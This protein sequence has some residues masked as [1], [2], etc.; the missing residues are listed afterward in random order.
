MYLEILA[1]IILAIRNIVLKQVPG[2][3]D[4]IT[5]FSLLA[6]IWG[7]VGIFMIPFSK[8]SSLTREEYIPLIGYA[9]LALLAQITMQNAFINST[10]IAITAALLSLN[11]IFS[12][13]LD[14]LVSKKFK[15]TPKQI[16][17]ICLILTGTV[18]VK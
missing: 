9:I 10:N 6:V 1:S 15:A 3:I 5:S 18:L 8:F 2:S 11:I 13:L 7:I 14:S 12:L 16:V 17:A 4:V